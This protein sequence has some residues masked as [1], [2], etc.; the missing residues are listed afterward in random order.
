MCAGKGI[1]RIKDTEELNKIKPILLKQNE[2]YI[3]SEYIT[4][5]L[6]WNKLKFHLRMYWLVIPEQNNHPFYQELHDT[7]KIM[8][9][10]FPYK[11]EDFDN[12]NR[13]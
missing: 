2:N 8:T 11:N 1:V 9:A 7:G 3:A 10:A 12:S 4:D 13:L 6:L 5:L